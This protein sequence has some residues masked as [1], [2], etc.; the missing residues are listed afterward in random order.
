[1]YYV[2]SFSSTDIINEML[3]YADIGQC[4]YVI[5]QLMRAAVTTV[6]DAE[7]D[8]LVAY[9]K[10]VKQYAERSDN[11]VHKVTEGCDIGVDEKA[12]ELKNP[13]GDNQVS[14]SQTIILKDKNHSIPSLII[15]A[16]SLIHEAVL[17]YEV[18]KKQ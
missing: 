10:H 9:I 18:E 15:L 2:E 3:L 5:P 14:R 13:K 17:Q 12:Y 8:A 11:L 1:M 16:N 6:A 7:Q 4:R